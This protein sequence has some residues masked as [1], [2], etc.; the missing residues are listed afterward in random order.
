[1]TSR[2]LFA[3]LL[4]SCLG[5]LVGPSEASACS[6]PACV[7]PEHV[8]ADGATV[9]A[10]AAGLQL[11]DLAP[12]TEMPSAR[13]FEITADGEVEVP[14]TLDRETFE[15]LLEGSLAQEGSYRLESDAGCG[16]EPAE[17]TFTAGPAAPLPTTLGALEAGPMS[18]GTV[19]VPDDSGSCYADVEA[20]VVD[21]S[22]GLSPEAEP[23]AS[24]FV[25]ETYVD[26]ELYAPAGTISPGSAYGDPYAGAAPGGSWVGRGVDRVYARCGGL[27]ESAWDEGVAEGTHTVEIRATLPGTD[28]VLVSEPAVVDLYCAPHPPRCDPSAPPSPE[29]PR[30][31]DCVYGRDPAT[32]ECMPWPE[33]PD[34]YDP[35]YDSEC[36]ASMY[37]VGHS[38][39]VT[40]AG[41]CSVSSRGGNGS[42]AALGLLAM[43]G[44][45]WRRR[46]S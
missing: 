27:P 1:M 5:L 12:L 15:I 6:G 32:G 38:G 17:A 31:T 23:W 10:N 46:R 22:L 45:L 34:T 9:P 41:G 42:A 35:T 37:Y 25:Y 2:V 44:L 43:V 8:P 24:L 19:P 28:V 14:I 16:L 3:S 7:A 29:C 40:E 20:V 21:V 39:P 36:P 33:C 13:L 11:L 4:A 30:P 18:W 26:G